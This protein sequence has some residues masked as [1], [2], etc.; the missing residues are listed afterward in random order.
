MTRNRIGALLAAALISPG[1]MAMAG[2]ESDDAAK[3][4]AKEVGR[5]LDD[6]AGNTDEKA[7]EAAED[8]VDAIDD[9]DGK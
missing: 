9:N 4:D 5:D 6:A 8:A 3:R 1:A 7:G 2:C